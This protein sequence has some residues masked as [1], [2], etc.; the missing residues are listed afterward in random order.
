M[1]IVERCMN[2]RLLVCLNLV[3]I[4]V[5]RGLWSIVLVSSYLEYL[6]GNDE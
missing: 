2:D 5:T 4:I 6:E 1:G 3:L